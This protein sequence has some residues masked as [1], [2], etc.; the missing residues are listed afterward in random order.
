MTAKQKRIKRIELLNQ[1][2]DLLRE[3]LK[4]GG[5][6][7]CFGD[8]VVESQGQIMDAIVWTDCKQTLLKK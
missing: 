1:A 5:H 3:V 6:H 8:H 7:P 4:L 2:D